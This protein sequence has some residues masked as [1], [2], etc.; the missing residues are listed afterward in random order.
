MK[1]FNRDE[2]EKALS[3]DSSLIISEYL[4]G[5]EYNVDCFTDKNGQLLV[6]KLRDRERIRAGISV[7]SKIIIMEQPIR[8][9]A[10]IINKKFVFKGA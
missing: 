4:P 2:L 9:M 5:M 8:D 3:K 6:A 7:R 1:V 10:E